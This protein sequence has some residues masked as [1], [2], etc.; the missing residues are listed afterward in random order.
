[1]PVGGIY[2]AGEHTSLDFQGYMN[3][4]A[5]T[6]REAA[7]MIAKKMKMLTGA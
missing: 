4:A 1:M 5:K 6:G 7:E 3:G 2:F